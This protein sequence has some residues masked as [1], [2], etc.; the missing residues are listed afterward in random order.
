MLVFL[1]FAISTGFLQKLD[2]L[3]IK[4]NGVERSALMYSPG[5]HQQ[6]PLVF[7]FHGF[8]GNARQAANS[9][10]VHLAWPEAV[11]V[12]PQGLR[13]RSPRLNRNGPGW[14][15]G[16]GQEED[17]DLIFFDHLLRY[18]KQK[19][20]IDPKRV[21][22]TGMSNGALFCYLLFTTKPESIAAFAPVAGAGGLWLTRATTARPFLIIHGNKDILVSPKTAELSRDAIIRINQCDTQSKEWI[23]GYDLYP[24]KTG[25]NP[26]IWYLHQGGHNWP[27]S[28]TDNIVKFFKE[29]QLL[30]SR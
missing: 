26:V 15:H 27:P 14:Q 3:E 6:K 19:Q 20:S 25:N 28:I 5:T 22:V 4:V 11:V 16:P 9:Y 12:Y 29:H 24:S 18:I 1:A 8:S 17:R 21:Y 23:K 13:V 30:G 7:V 2:T 10:K